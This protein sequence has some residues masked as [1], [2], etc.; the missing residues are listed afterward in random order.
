M[1]KLKILIACEFSGV[2]RNEFRKLGHDAFSCDIEP[3]DDNSPYHYQCD[4]RNVINAYQWDLMIAHPPCTYLTLA[5]N[6]WFKE[7]YKE[8]YPTREKDRQ[9]GID[10]FM[11]L[12][13]AN[14]PHIAVEN[15]IGIMSSAYRKPNQIVQPW[16]F[17]DPFQKSTCLWLKNLPNLQPTDIVSKG[18]FIEWECKKTGRIKR[19]P[20]WYADAFQKTS[21]PIERQKIRNKTFLGM[22]KAIA[23]QYS[24]YII[25]QQNVL[26]AGHSGVQNTGHFQDSSHLSSTAVEQ[27]K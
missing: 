14:I 21:N 12:M 16:Q 10:F 15:P 8:K 11:E 18:E 3:S 13:N 2:L 23:H 7:E 25:G 20:K 9:N 5:G 6:R 26:N 27:N 22:A 4:V 17:G 24:D 1:K 19:Q